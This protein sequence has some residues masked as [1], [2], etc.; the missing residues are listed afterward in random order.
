M[1]ISQGL[2]P[3]RGGGLTLDK[4]DMKNIESATAK[5]FR[6]WRKAATSCS[7]EKLVQLIKNCREAADEMRRQ[8]NPVK[9][10]FYEDQEWIFTDVYLER[11]RANT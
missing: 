11:K 4:T 6:S 5:D 7:N 10:E 8:S 3:I 9:A 2:P 1:A